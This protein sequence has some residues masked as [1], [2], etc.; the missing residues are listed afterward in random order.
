MNSSKHRICVSDTSVTLS[1]PR[2]R[3]SKSFKNMTTD[4]VFANPRS[5]GKCKTSIAYN[6][7]RAGCYV[8]LPRDI[9][10]KKAVINVQSMDNACFA[11]SV[12][13]DLYPAEKNSERKSSYPHYTTVLNFDDPLLPIII[14]RTTLDFPRLLLLLFFMK[15]NKL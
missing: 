3:P 10:T 6:P 13:A 12:V 5:Y 7:M 14:D 9:T 11:W 4:G 2:W 1:N 15:T 8:K